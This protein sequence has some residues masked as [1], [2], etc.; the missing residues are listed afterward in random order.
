MDWVGGDK[1]NQHVL[2]ELA[3]SIEHLQLSKVAVDHANT[4]LKKEKVDK[5]EAIKIVNN[6]ISFAIKGMEREKKTILKNIK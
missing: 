6:M 5:K 1:Q 2:L 4:V 3:K